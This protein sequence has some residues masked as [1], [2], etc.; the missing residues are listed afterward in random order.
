MLQI[1]L[2]DDPSRR[3]LSPATNEASVVVTLVPL[4]ACTS[5]PP[6][7]SRHSSV[8]SSLTKYVVQPWVAVVQSSSELD[9]VISRQ[10]PLDLNDMP[11]HSPWHATLHSISVLEGMQLFPGP[12][13]AL[14]SNVEHPTPLE[15]AFL[16]LQ[17][18]LQ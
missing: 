9:F 12:T 16:T 11:L 4:S 8:S 3:R 15:L 1:T 13:A 2:P 7:F 18:L 5:W 17:S 6:I 10:K 14:E